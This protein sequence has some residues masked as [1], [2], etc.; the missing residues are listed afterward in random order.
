MK[1]CFV[2]LNNSPKKIHKTT[3]TFDVI[4]KTPIPKDMTVEKII[5]ETVMGDY[6]INN[7][8]MIRGKTNNDIFAAGF[9]RL[10]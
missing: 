5:V 8:K 1:N 4:S 7:C 10:N 3:I 2:M 9:F 6:Q